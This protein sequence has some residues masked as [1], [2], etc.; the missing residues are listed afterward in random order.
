MSYSANQVEIHRRAA[1]SVD[2]D[3]QGSKTRLFASGAA[4]E[5]RVYDQSQD[6]E[7]DWCDNSSVGAVSGGQGDQMTGV[8]HQWRIVAKSLALISCALLFALGLPAEAQQANKISR[9]GFL[10]AASSS[11]QS[12]NV[13]AFR[14]GLRDIGYVERKNIVVEY[15]YA[16][17]KPHRLDDFAAELAHAKIDVIVTAGSQA[18]SA[19]KKATNT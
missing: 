2:K 15:R 12:A 13:E 8:K 9:I 6:S 11:S 3:T 17:E 1:V 19:A 5:V 4:D 14:R 16:E 10:S 18:T 7:T